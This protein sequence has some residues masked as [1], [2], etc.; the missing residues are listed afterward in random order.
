LCEPLLLEFLS[1]LD[2][3]PSVYSSGLSVRAPSLEQF[4]APSRLPTIAR[5]GI[6]FLL[7]PLRPNI[8]VG[9]IF[10]CRRFD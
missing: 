8:L 4:A 3:A 1:E 5:I 10:A 2:P 6:A 9:E 7:N